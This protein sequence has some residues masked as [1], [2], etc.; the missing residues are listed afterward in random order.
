[1]NKYPEYDTVQKCLQKIEAKLNWGSSENWHN[2]V[3][4]E[5]SEAIYNKT[6]VLISTTT[7]KRIWG[8]VNYNN[9]PSISTLNTLSQ[10]I[11]YK[12]WRDFKTSLTLT[13]NVTLHP[14]KS[15]RFNL[16]KTLIVGLVFLVAALFLNFAFKHY[17]KE[18]DSSQIKFISHSVTASIP[19]SVVF[20]FDISNIDSDSI[21]IQQFWDPTKTIKINSEQKQATGIYYYP[22]Y[23][24]A[25]LLVNGNTLK[26]HDLFIK[27]NGWLGTIDYKPIPK[28]ISNLKELK[29]SEAIK[30]E[31][32]RS[33]APLTTT[34]QYIDKFEGFSGDN[35]S[36]SAEIKSI[37]NDKWAV[38]QSTSVIVVGTKSALIIPLS[39]IG[40]SSELRGMLSD[41]DLDGK[42]EDL[43][44]LAIELTD[45]KTITIEC[46]NKQVNVFF[47]GRKV[48]TKTYEESI[49]EIAGVRY[50]FLGIGTVE[51]VTLLNKKTNQTIAL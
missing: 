32:K 41:K 5:L 34:F 39:L 8:K 13:K 51:N 1:M 14:K 6:G 25:K 31:V 20:D 4:S 3:F 35:F 49:G 33:K 48:F 2:N 27:S 22:G 12:N 43:S 44:S 7:L 30:E 37:Y 45:F 50:K 19:N 46:I 17:N 47:E 36:L 40:C 42:T 21:Y 28:Y 23:F 16:S 15:I 26:E 11:G 9:A 10:F 24:R 18:I 38:C 29:F